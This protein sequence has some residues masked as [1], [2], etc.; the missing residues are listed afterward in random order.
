MFTKGP[1]E[2]YL[3]H[4]QPWIQSPKCPCI[5]LLVG[6]W[7]HS[8]LQR[9]HSLLPL[10]LQ[11]LLCSLHL[12]PSEMTTGSDSLLGL[13]PLQPGTL[14]TSPVSLSLPQAGMKWVHSV[15]ELMSVNVCAEGRLLR[16]VTWWGGCLPMQGDPEGVPGVGVSLIVARR[17][18]L[19]GEE[20]VC[21]PPASIPRGCNLIPWDSPMP[22]HPPLPSLLGCRLF[23][24]R[25]WGRVQGC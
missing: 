11:Q 21:D 4:P 12:V 23:S 17:G 10:C 5:S 13:C 18:T 19:G 3:Y 20:M 1:S 7:V 6:L 24:S 25:S 8:H 16:R 22:S 9:P 2:I 14:S 15:C